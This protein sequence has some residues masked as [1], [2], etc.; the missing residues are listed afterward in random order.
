M[1]P[2]KEGD[3]KVKVWIVPSDTWNWFQKQSRRTLLFGCFLRCIFSNIK[4]MT[5]FS[6]FDKQA[7]VNATQDEVSNKEA[8]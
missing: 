5:L 6:H 8:A 3:G 1:F 2:S 4:T 7:A